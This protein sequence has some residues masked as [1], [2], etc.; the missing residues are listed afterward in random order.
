MWDFARKSLAF[1]IG[2]ALLT[3][4]KLRQLAD[5]A[6]ARGEM[7]S[8]EAKNFVD[9]VTKRG[10]EEKRNL[11]SWMREQMSK[12]MHEAGVVE[13][14][15]FEAIER[16]IEAVERRVRALELRVTQDEE[17]QAEEIGEII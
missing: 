8:D 6:V 3:T 12:M 4:E 5:E 13:K 11:Q 17:V 1:G 9:D 7:T 2:A 14:S 16:R 15:E 10:E